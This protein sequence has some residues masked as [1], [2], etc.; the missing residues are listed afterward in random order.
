M[1]PAA[2]PAR[3]VSSVR[4]PNG[5]SRSQFVS[6][7]CYDPAHEGFPEARRTTRLEAGRCTARGAGTSREPAGL[8]YGMIRIA[9]AVAVHKAISSTLPKGSGRWPMQREGD[10]CFIQ[11]EQATLER[12]RAMRR[13]GESYGDVILRLV[14]SEV[15][16]RS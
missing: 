4:R 11:V 16:Q 15:G 9:I 3:T 5:A 1:R 2:T 10:R 6:G 7:T 14:A 12:M 13:P 8:R